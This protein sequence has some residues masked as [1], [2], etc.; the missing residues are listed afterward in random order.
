MQG[1]Q[2]ENMGSTKGRTGRTEDNEKKKNVC[3]GFT[4]K[5]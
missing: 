5:N 2:S 3:L 4:L 1:N